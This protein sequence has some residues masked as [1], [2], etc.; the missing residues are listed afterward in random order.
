MTFPCFVTPKSVQERPI[1]FQMIGSWGAICPSRTCAFDTCFL[2]ENTIS[3]LRLEIKKN[4]VTMGV[5]D[6][7]LAQLVRASGLHPEGRRFE[8]VIAHWRKAL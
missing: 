5:C 2:G 1:E 3:D 6:G 4:S 8:P 7:R